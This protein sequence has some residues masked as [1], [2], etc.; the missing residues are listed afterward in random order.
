MD[1]VAELARL[2]ELHEA[3]A[4]S[5][6][7][8]A[9][10][11]ARVLQSTGAVPGTDESLR[12]VSTSQPAGPV[13]GRTRPRTAMVLV[14]AAAAVALLT[15]LGGL[16][17]ALTGG[18]DENS[19]ARDKAAGQVY[20]ASDA[21][22]FAAVSHSCD[23]LESWYEH[24]P[25]DNNKRVA[26]QYWDEC[27]KVPPPVRSFDLAPWDNDA[28]F[29]S[30]LAEM[31]PK[32]DAS[33]ADDLV[34]NGR[35]L[36]ESAQLGMKRWEVDKLVTDNGVSAEDAATLLTVSVTTMCPE[37]EALL[38]ASTEAPDVPTRAELAAQLDQA[39]A[40]RY[41]DKW[42]RPTDREV[43]QTAKS[44]C[45]AVENGDPTAGVLW[46]TYIDLGY[47]NLNVY[48]E[49]AGISMSIVC[50]DSVSDVAD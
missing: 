34:S 5:D 16:A 22:N 23:E 41:G 4:L 26:E 38:N 40:D 2:A 44:I 3:G 32:S 9:Q 47:D 11:K 42:N 25:R 8:F 31:Y 21:D 50:P 49:A 48:G 14:G 45:Y 35:L 7:E 19:T 36:C 20:D 46:S 39:F 43:M 18:S 13:A 27:D 15:G 30:L 10:A 1:V 17:L 33:L 12:D 29:A 24:L 28:M 37:Y 6:E